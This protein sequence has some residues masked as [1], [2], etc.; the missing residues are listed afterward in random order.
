MKALS[1][2]DVCLFDFD[3]LPRAGRG[4]SASGPWPK[5]WRSSQV[6]CMME[7][8]QLLWFGTQGGGLEPLDGLRFRNFQQRDGLVNDY[9]LSMAEGNGRLWFGTRDGISRFDGGG[10]QQHCISFNGGVA[11]NGLHCDHCGR[12]WA[13]TN[14]GLFRLLGD[15]AVQ[16]PF[17][18]Q[19]NLGRVFLDDD[20]RLWLGTGD[21][22]LFVS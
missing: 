14:Q 13:A 17:K 19:A 9:I 6:Y 12:L 21:Q 8:S 18:L 22:G 5:A 7:D 2:S 10:I 1:S 16:Q 11:V 3:F 15:S 20:E 4:P